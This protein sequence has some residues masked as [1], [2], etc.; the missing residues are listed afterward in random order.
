MA[1][2]ALD[3]LV[4]ILFIFILT[5]FICYRSLEEAKGLP[6][7]EQFMKYI[8]F[9]FIDRFGNLNVLGLQNTLDYIIGLLPY[10]VFLLASSAI[11]AILI[12]VLFGALSS[13]KRGSKVDLLL[14]AGFVTLLM[15][16]NWWSAFFILVNFQQWFPTGHWQSYDWAITPFWSNPLGKIQDLLWH[17]TLPMLSLMI[18]IVGIYFI[19]SRNCIVNTL[20]EPYII[21]AK[22]KGLKTHSIILRHALRNAIIPIVAATSLAPVFLINASLSVERTYSLRGI[23]WELYNS[24]VLPSELPRSAILPTLPAIFFLLSLV[25]VAI[26]YIIDVSNYQLDPR[27]GRSMTDGAGFSDLFKSVRWKSRKIKLK[28]FLTSFMR[29][30]SGK[31]GLVIILFLIALAVL[32]PFLPLRDPKLIDYTQKNQSPSLEHL[33][34]TDEFGRDVLSRTIWAAQVSLV[35]SLGA[36]II[37]IVVGTLVGMVSGYYRDQP[38]GYFLDRVTDVFLSVPLIVVVLFFPIET[39]SLKWVLAVGLSAWAIVAKV[40]RSQVLVTREKPYFES[41]KAVGVGKIRIFLFYIL[42]D[43]MGVIAANMVYVA[44]IIIAIQTSLDFFGF[45]RFLWSRDPEVR[46]VMIAPTLNWGSMLSYNLSSF[47]SLH[48]WWTVVPPLV[49]ITLLGLSLILIG[50]KTTEVLNPQI[51]SQTHF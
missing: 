44:G 29:G 34:G 27:L 45:K 17:T 16:P 12:G 39:E 50:N 3:S 7:A 6:E 14:L 36:L 48:T 40:V 49:C 25:T 18:S 8:R 51:G 21:T 43:A 47:L 32:A 13:Y 2:R 15:V 5:F 22:A 9:V 19:V 46:P 26:H 28:A 38:L 10:S 41:A 37:A 4:T 42:P 11:I 1:K 35:E 31:L 33:F 23:G 24:M 30:F 20:N